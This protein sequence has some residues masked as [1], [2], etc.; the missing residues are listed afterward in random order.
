M[1]T[2]PALTALLLAPVFMLS[3]CWTAPIASVQPKGEARLIQDG[4]IAESARPA[5]IIESTDRTAGTIV[6]RPLGAPEAKTYKV[7]R[8]VENLSELRIGD[9]VTPTVREEL[10]IYVLRDGRAPGPDG[11]RMQITAD[12]RVLTVDPSYRLLQLQYP[13]GERQTLK[14]ALGVRL[15]QMAAGDTVVIRP[16]EVIDLRRKR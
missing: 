9:R 7:G 13:D 11:A 14:L 16:I 15:E 6:L 5:A 1:Q 8:E 4:I 10:S 2:H 12:A 3:G